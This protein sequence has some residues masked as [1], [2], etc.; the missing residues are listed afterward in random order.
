MLDVAGRGAM[1]ARR[2]RRLTYHRRAVARNRLRPRHRRIRWDRRPARDVG[3][4]RHE[5]RAHRARRGAK[6]GASL[7][8][9]TMPFESRRREIDRAATAERDGQAATPAASAVAASAIGS[10]AIIA[11]SSSFTWRKSKQRHHSRD[12]RERLQRRAAR[13][14]HGRA[15]AS[16]GR[17]R[18]GRESAGG[19]SCAVSRSSS[20]PLIK[21]M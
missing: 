1:R 5:R 20:Q 8:D 14:L 7:H 10:G 18:S 2:S 17:S 6:R 15:A 13:R 9:R 21:L 11:I 3:C 16:A 12:I 4:R 19:C